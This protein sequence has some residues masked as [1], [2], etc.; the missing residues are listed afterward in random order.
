MSKELI[1]ARF[2]PR[3]LPALIWK[4]LGFLL[5]LLTDANLKLLLFRFLIGFVVV[6]SHRVFE[7]GVDV[8]TGRQDRHNREAFVT[9]RA[10]GPKALYVRD[11]HNC[12]RI[13]RRALFRSFPTELHNSYNP[14][15]S[16]LVLSIK[17]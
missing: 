1:A 7:V 9:G 4:L 10:E 14:N 11:G 17:E 2:R 15:G 13:A 6:A 12:F 3:T 8:H 5:L 16:G